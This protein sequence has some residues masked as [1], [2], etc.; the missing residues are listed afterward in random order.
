MKTSYLTYIL[1]ADHSFLT[2]TLTS[3][4]TIPFDIYIYIYIFHAK[5]TLF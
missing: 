5:I 1:G 2:L 3:S 4:I